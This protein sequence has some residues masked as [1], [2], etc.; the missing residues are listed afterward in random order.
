M[1]AQYPNRHLSQEQRCQWAGLLPDTADEIGAPD[2]SQPG[3]A[4]DPNAPMPKWGRD[5]VKG[6]YQG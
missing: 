4:A 6:P 1:I 3:A 5:E 2:D